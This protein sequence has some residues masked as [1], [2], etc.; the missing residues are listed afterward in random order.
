MSDLAPFVAAALRDRTLND[1]IEENDKLKQKLQSQVN[2]N[3]NEKEKLF[4]QITGPKHS[5]MYIYIEYIL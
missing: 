1:L 4:V 5:P 2:E 3:K